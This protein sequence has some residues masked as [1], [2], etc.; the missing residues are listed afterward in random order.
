MLEVKIYKRTRL[1]ELIY[2]LKAKLLA[3]K[4]FFGFF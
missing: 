3:L 2:S 4:R 1:R